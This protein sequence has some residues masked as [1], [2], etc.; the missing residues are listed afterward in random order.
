MKVKVKK[1]GA[2]GSG[3]GGV[4]ENQRISWHQRM[5]QSGCVHIERAFEF[6]GP[7]VLVLS[8]AKL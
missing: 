2:G 5:V 7:L 3:G 4:G 6:R 8:S 1:D